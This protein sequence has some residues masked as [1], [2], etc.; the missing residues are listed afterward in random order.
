MK[1]YEIGTGYTPIP[2]QIAAATESVVEE[3]TKAF[4]DRDVDVEI[5]DIYSSN[6]VANNLPI[7]QVKVPSMFSRSDVKLGIVHKLKRVVYSLALASKLKNLLKATDEKVV[8]HFHNQYNMFFFIKSVSKKLRSRAITAY[9]NHNGVWNMPWE[10]A[11]GTLKKRYF[12][13]IAAMKEADIS[14]VLNPKT[15]ENVEKQLGL[16]R[17]RVV[18]ID[19]GVNTDIYSPLSPDKIERIKGKYALGGKRVILQVG[20]VNENKGQVRS[21]KMLEPLLRQNDDL[22]FAYVGGI[23]SQE[24]FDEV[25]RTAKELGLADRVIYLGTVSPGEEMNEIYNIALATIFSSRYESFGLVCIESLSA[26]VP[27]IICSDSLLDFGDGCIVCNPENFNDKVN[28]EIFSNDEYI[29]LCEKARK[30]AEQNYTWAKIA[31]DY[32]SVMT[33]KSA[34]KSLVG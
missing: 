32:Y 9:T 30:N 14:F 17:E 33:F 23:V 11:E 26:G 16:P 10:K 8:L 12:Q 31:E 34:I 19:N 18:H 4:M 1:I 7:T 28:E 2:A 6:R 13:E 27:V 29:Q 24:Y 3:L 22:V 25:E 15:K 5:I 20:S 21:L